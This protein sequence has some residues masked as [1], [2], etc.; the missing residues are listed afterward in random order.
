MLSNSRKTQEKLAVKKKAVKDEK[1][2]WSL[3]V[4]E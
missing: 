4:L 1:D 2:S 3:L